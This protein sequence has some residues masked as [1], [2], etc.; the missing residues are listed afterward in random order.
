M[1]KNKTKDSRPF[2]ER[3]PRWNLVLGLLLV[4]ILI[5]LGLLLLYFAFKYIGTGISIFVDWLKNIASKLDAVVI[6]ALITGAVSITGV[7]ISSIISKV[8][9]YKKQRQTYL[10]QKREKSY[11][12]FV[13]MV[14]KIQQNS[15]KE[16]SYTEQDM[17]DDMVN[18][19]QELTLW[20]SK[21]VAYKWVKFRL[22]GAKPDTAKENLFVLEDIMNEMRKDM[23]VKKTKKGKLL[24][25][26]VNDIENAMKKK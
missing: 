1:K 3:H 16:G 24:S 12:A 23:G 14:Y 8:Y 15:K 26:F 11:G 9:D 7:V 25:F 5:G 20:G 19:S 10:A 18:F 13:E 21:K 17:L 22:N 2:S 4:L 6:V